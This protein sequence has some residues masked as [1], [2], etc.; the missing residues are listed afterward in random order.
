MWT[1]ESKVSDNVDKIDITTDPLLILSDTTFKIEIRLLEPIP[2]WSL[3]GYL[4]TASG[5]AEYI[6]YD[7]RPIILTY[8]N[9]VITNF[10]VGQL[11]MPESIRFVF[12]PLSWVRRVEYDFILHR[13]II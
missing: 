3:A 8:E 13:Y 11:P 4:Y 10:A 6:L 12:R 2:T 5:N 9:L 1:L 7:T